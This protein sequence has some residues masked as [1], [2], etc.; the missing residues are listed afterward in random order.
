MQKS[1]CVKSIP[2]GQAVISGSLI[3][4]WILHENI[5]LELEAFAATLFPGV[6]NYFGLDLGPALAVKALNGWW[7]RAGAIFGI[8]GAN[9][10]YPRFALVNQIEM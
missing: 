2:P 3:P 9:Q 1:G 6:Y 4:Q 8:A 7:M 10:A 5:R